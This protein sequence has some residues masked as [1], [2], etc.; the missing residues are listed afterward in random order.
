[1]S[2][3]YDWR[4]DVVR[5][6]AT[7][8]RLTPLD[9]P[10]VDADADATIKMSFS[11]TFLWDDSV[12]WLSD[13]LRPVQ[14][15]D[16]IDHPVGTFPVGTVADAYDANGIHS[17]SVEAYDRCLVLEQHKTETVRHFPKGESYINIV[18]SLLLEAGIMLHMTTPS[19][20]VLATDREDWEIGTPYLTIINQLLSE[21]SYEDIWFDARGY[22]VIRPERELS[23]DNIDHRYGELENIRVLQRPCSTET[24]IFDKA[25]VFV[26]VCANPDLPEPLTATA[27]NDN[28]MSRLSTIRRG[29]RIVSVVQVDNIPD[30]AALEDYA[31][32]LRLESMLAGEVA[33]ISTVNLP[34]HGIRDTVALMHP[35]I[36]GL[37]QEV[38]WSLTLGLQQQMVH[39]LR[40]YAIV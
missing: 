18:L 2:R 3:K 15:I 14:I 33:T 11:G 1:M 7:F 9:E 17:V 21:I 6:G 25:N 12:E 30:Q 24:D 8:T 13:E 22:A 26:V 28:P 40:R 4:V 35:D 38:G 29:R 10:T 5:N 32:K 36:N 37:Y 20:A 34:M 39:R 16:G 31:G 23:A 19:D 27:V